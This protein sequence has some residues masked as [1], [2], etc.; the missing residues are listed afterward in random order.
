MKASRRTFIKQTS[1][2]VA[3]A[4]AFPALLES[5]SPNA[6]VPQQS[7]Q[8]GNK[9]YWD[10]VRDKFPLTH[11]R[12]YFNTGTIGPNPLPVQEAYKAAIEDLDKRGEYGGWEIARPKL[13]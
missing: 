6:P 9:Q 4:L 8:S 13:A 5:A 7:T 2:V 11:D 3:G 1:G 12:V 10:T